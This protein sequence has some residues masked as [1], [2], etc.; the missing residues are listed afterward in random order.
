MKNILVLC[1][2]NSCRSQLAE[3]YCASLQA[4][5]QISVVP[6]LR[7]QYYSVNEEIFQKMPIGFTGLFNFYRQR[8]VLNEIE[9]S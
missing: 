9:S 4:I 8:T 6:V 7:N 5:R 3:G 1:T 2:G